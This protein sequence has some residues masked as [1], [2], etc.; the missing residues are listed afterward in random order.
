MSSTERSRIPA[1]L[2][3]D[4]SPESAGKAPGIT[5]SPGQFRELIGWLAARG[6]T[7]ISAREWLQALNGTGVLPAKPI[8]ITF[9]DAYANIAEH[10]LPVLQSQGF[11]ATVFVVT[12]LIGQTNE[13]D[14]PKW[15]SLPLMDVG[16]IRA[17]AASGME[18]GSHSCTHPDLTRLTDSELRREI[19]RSR[20]ELASVI[21]AP[22]VSFAYP[23]GR[24]NERVRQIVSQTYNL[25]FST[26]RGLV[27]PNTNPMLCCR[28][29]VFPRYSPGRVGLYLRFASAAGLYDRLKRSLRPFLFPQPQTARR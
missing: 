22:V 20:D 3:H 16:Q 15:R 9:D 23:F 18:F 27:T 25:A 14:T 29:E 2:F 19:V 21:G 6:Y 13:W 28:T 10:A 12:S 26:E 5:V 1:L 7:G 17:W 4:V 24:H 11:R 8:V